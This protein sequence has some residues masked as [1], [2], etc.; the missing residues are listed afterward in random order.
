MSALMCWRPGHWS[1]TAKP[2]RHC[3]APTNLR[4]ETGQ[5]SH[6]VCAEA[7]AERCADCGTGTQLREF[8]EPLCSSCQEV[9]G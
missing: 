4:D 1:T 5:P 7:L 3:A 8:G 6:K 9:A 2:C